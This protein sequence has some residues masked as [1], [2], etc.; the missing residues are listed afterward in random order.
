MIDL[1]QFK[2]LNP[3]DVSDEQMMYFRDELV[4]MHD[5]LVDIMADEV[6]KYDTENF[7]PYSFRGERILKKISKKH[8]PKIAE[9]DMLIEVID[10]EMSRRDTYNE[11]QRY[12]EGGNY[13]KFNDTTEEFLEKEQKKIDRKRDDYKD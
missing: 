9:V 5:E 11:Q 1:E 4:K 8:A 13:K 3:S 6:K 12:I 2:V 10:D 7:D